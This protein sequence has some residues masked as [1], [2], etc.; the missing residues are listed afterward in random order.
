MRV[1]LGQLAGGVREL[2]KYG[3]MKPEAEQGIDE[4]RPHEGWMKLCIR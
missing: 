4:V 1:R 2:G 3:P